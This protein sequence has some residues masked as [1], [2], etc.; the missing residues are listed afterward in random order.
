VGIKFQGSRAQILAPVL[1]ELKDEQE[2]ELAVTSV[3][4]FEDPQSTMP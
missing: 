3:D 1:W 2:H 4:E